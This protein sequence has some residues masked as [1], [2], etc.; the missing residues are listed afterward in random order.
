MKQI[1]Q[2]AIQLKN[3]RKSTGYHLI[4]HP[5]PDK[6]RQKYATTWQ[7]EGIPVQQ[8]KIVSQQ[9]TNIDQVPTFKALKQNIKDVSRDTKTI[10][11]VG[12]SSGYHAKVI[13]S[14][15][16]KISYV[17]CD[18]STPFIKIAQK[19]HPKAKFIVADAVNL[20]F[21]TQSFDT[22]ISGCCLL[23]IIDY[24]TAIQETVRVAKNMSFF[25]VRQLFT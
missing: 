6:L 23:H 7:A 10:L 1:L 8:N 4:A 17:G 11:E 21:S 22:V 19:T 25:I 15:R 18:I 16:K 9:L 24:E 14:L 13:A 5:N 3:R 20:S 2:K 12:C